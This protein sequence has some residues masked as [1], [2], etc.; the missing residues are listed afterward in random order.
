MK[1]TCK[2]QTDISLQSTDWTIHLQFVTCKIQTDISLQSTDWTIHL[3]F[4]VTCK[5]PNWHQ[6]TVHRLDNPSVTTEVLLSSGRTNKFLIQL[7]GIIILLADRLLRH[8]EDPP[9]HKELGPLSAYDPRTSQEDGFNQSIPSVPITGGNRR[10][11]TENCCY[12]RLTISTTL[13]LR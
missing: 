11:C 1:V 10:N 12:I 5:I 2:I 3:Q 7:E 13:F 6:S 9:C 8:T 4:V